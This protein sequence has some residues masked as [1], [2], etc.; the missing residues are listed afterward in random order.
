MAEANGR[1]K[2][3]L[4]VTVYE[5]CPSCKH[6]AIRPVRGMPWIR[7]PMR[8]PL[9]TQ[10]C[11]CT[12]EG[13][14]GFPIISAHRVDEDDLQTGQWAQLGITNLLAGGSQTVKDT[15]GNT[16]TVT[17]NSSVSALTV[18]CGTGTTAAAV[19]DN[20][21]QTPSSGW[22]GGTTV[23]VGSL[24]ESGTSGSF[25]ITC[26]LTNGNASLVNVG[27]IGVTVTVAT[28][29]YLILHDAPINASTPYYY[30]VSPNG[31]LACTYTVSNA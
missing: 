22:T 29:V 15:S 23:T 21:L 25:T 6:W 4:E 19:S 20:A 3:R 14:P 12:R 13:K 31:T 7:L 24:T 30:P 28:Y 17:N 18:V 16:H 8:V 2:V 5:P 26:T 9:S 10:F 1:G 11:K 27:E